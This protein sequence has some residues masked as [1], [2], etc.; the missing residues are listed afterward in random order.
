MF[1]RKRASLSSPTGM[2]RPAAIALTCLAALRAGA[3]TVE[4]PVAFDVRFRGLT[5]AAIAGLAR[6]TPEAYAANLRVRATGLASLFARTRFDMRVEGFRDGG[7]LT[8]FSYREIVDT[9]QR[10]SAVE[11]LWPGGSGPVLL[12]QP[13]VVEAGLRAVTAEEA[14][15]A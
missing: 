9:G 2:R 14:E 3:E 12:S 6:E 7:A 10:A 13:P 15:G 4:T 8:P 11:L 1:D 5:V